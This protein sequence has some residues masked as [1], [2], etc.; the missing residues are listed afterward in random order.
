ME[1]IRTCKSFKTTASSR[2]MVVLPTPGRPL[3]TTSMTDSLQAVPRQ[4]G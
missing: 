3:S 1:S 2:A 4:T